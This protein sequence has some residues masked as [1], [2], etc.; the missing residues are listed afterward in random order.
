MVLAM[1]WK[2]WALVWKV[3][4]WKQLAPTWW[5]LVWKAPAGKVLVDYWVYFRRLLCPRRRISGVQQESVQQSY[6]E[7][8]CEEV[9]S[10]SDPL[11]PFIFRPGAPGSKRQPAVRTIKREPGC[12]IPYSRIRSTQHC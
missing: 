7:M 10:S 5:A 9:V 11:F 2:Q 1:V 8:P 4:A 12:I 3:P 6:F